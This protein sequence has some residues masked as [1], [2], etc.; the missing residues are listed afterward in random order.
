MKDLRRRIDLLRDE[1]DRRQARQ[2]VTTD[3]L[4]D[5]ILALFTAAV[6]DDAPPAVREQAGRC[7]GLM[8]LQA[9]ADCSPLT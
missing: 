8:G 9:A 3:M 1:V 4:L 5:R 7:A 2:P 6:K